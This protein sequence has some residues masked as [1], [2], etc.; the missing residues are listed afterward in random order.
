MPA[1]PRPAPAAAPRAATP[2]A[3]V[4]AVLLAYARYGVPPQGALEAAQVS[5][6]LLDDATAC[7]TSAQFERLCAHAMQELDDEALGWFSRR[8]P[9][10]SYGLLCRASLGAPTLG[11]ALKRWCRHHR[12]LTD[13]LHLS[14]TV[15]G[16][17]AV[18]AI[19]ERVDLAAMREFC[20]VSSLRYLHGYA[21]WA[22]DSR[23]AL[24]EVAL[25][26][27]RPPH[28]AVHELIFPGPV[29]H[30]AARTQMRLDA[31]YLELPLLRDE[32]ALGG[33]L[34]HALPLTVR[35]YRRDRLLADSVRHLLRTRGAELRT[36]ESLA[37]ALGQSSRTLHR[38]LADQGS[39]V[40][41]LRDEV[42]CDQALHLLHRTAKPVKQ[43]AEA[44][45]F[46]DEKSFIRAFKGWTGRSPG[47]LRRRRSSG[48]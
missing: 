31:S 3:F 21:C 4:R 17:D 41:R 10:G 32:A 48:P 29:R 14:L 19:D 42:R 18:V 26:I 16:G 44:V 38:Q 8:L 2:M 39:S 33:M 23:I 37:A 20:L 11:L 47:D 5:P 1:R 22:V 34:Q 13:D 40:Q 12:L 25:P 15:E 28:G 35:P 43:V 7:I 24:R 27:A 6:S 46:K 45:G 36:A 9:W 30:G